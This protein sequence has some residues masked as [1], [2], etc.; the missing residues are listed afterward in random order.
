MPV[1]DG[2]NLFETV[3]LASGALLLVVLVGVM[4]MLALKGAAF[5]KLLPF[6]VFPIVMI[7]WPSIRTFEF[8]TS[9]GKIKLSIGTL[10][11]DPADSNARKA[12]KAALPKV[13][14]G[15]S[16][17]P[18]TLTLVA[19]AALALGDTKVATDHID[20]ALQL[21]PTFAD[22]TRLQGRIQA[23]ESLPTLTKQVEAAPFD[24]LARSHLEQ[25]IAGITSTPVLNPTTLSNIARGQAALGDITRALSNTQTALQIDPGLPQ[26]LE[27]RQKIRPTGTF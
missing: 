19:R 1:V 16:S 15:S 17:D 5:A 6:F 22:A 13:E 12:L 25:S 10:E 3:M 27:L 8:S 21:A 26:A 23:E 18:G 20:R 4:V 11:N 9:L 2:L 24:A 7:G 14:N